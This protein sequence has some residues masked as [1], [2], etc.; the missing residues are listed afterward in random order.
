MALKDENILGLVE[1]I[2]EGLNRMLFVGCGTDIKDYE[3]FEEYVE[4]KQKLKKEIEA[5]NFK[6]GE[7]MVFEEIENKKKSD[8][9]EGKN[10]ALRVGCWFFLKLNSLDEET[11]NKGKY[12]KEDVYYGIKKVEEFV[13]GVS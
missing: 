9:V 6:K 7:E 13:F 5:K 3:N 12:S 1:N 4:F 11:L 2:S 8:D 10:S